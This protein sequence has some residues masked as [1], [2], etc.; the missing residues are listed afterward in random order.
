MCKKLL[1]LVLPIYLILS[2]TVLFAKEN[3]NFQDLSEDHWAYESINLMV[4]KDILEGFSDGTFRPEKPIT[5]EQFAKVLVLSLNLNLEN[6]DVQTFS[7]IPKTHWAY[8]YIETAKKFLTGYSSSGKLFFK[9]SEL[10]VREDMAVAIVLAKGLNNDVLDLTVL[11]SY[12]DKDKISPKLR[13]YIAIAIK[14]KIMEGYD[15]GNFG[16][17]NT[18]T[19]AEACTLINKAGII[20]NDEKVVVE[21]PAAVE[22]PKASV[23]S[24]A[25]NKTISVTF[26]NTYVNGEKVMYTLDGSN[27]DPRYDNRNRKVWDGKPIVI[28][29]STVLKAVA[30][31]TPSTIYEAMR[32][33]TVSTF[34][35]KIEYSN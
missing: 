10:A 35:Y 13:N 24:G 22:A 33:S 1:I 34:E 15:N 20:S 2:S 23:G 18:L 27:P 21:V 16:A 26:T 11:D 6:P 12:K 8:Q 19:R 3:T 30:V 32:A 31:T 25:Y 9:G 14:N 4:E 17:Q 29:Q 28:E 5:R 7:D